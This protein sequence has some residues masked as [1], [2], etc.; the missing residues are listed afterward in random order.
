MQKNKLINILEEVGLTDKEANIYFT[1]LSLGPSTILK[2]SQASGIKRTTAYPIIESLKEKGLAIIEVKGFKKLFIPSNP[3][4][5]EK[6]LEEKKEKVKKLLPEFLSLYNLEEGSSFIKYYEGL[7]SVK[8]IYENILN[9]L[10]H[11]ED[12]LI[13]GDQK[14]WYELDPEFF[15]KFI[16]KRAK[17]SRKLKIKIKILFQDSQIARLHKAREKNYNEKVKILPKETKLSTNLVITSKKV[18]IHQLTMPIMAIVIENKSIIQMH[19]ELFEI[20]WKTN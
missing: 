18:I 7:K 12:Y 13:I 6:T 8:S 20:M 5:I 4:N 9:E 16:D 1:M 19:K 2:I 3:K 14:K 11:Q 15:Q 10:E 17:L